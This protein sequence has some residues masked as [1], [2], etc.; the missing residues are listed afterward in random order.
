MIYV[1]EVHENFKIVISNP[2]IVCLTVYSNIKYT[3]NAFVCCKIIT[4]KLSLFIVHIGSV[5]SFMIVLI[6]RKRMRA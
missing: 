4:P 2:N 6:V 5:K 3:F 1:V